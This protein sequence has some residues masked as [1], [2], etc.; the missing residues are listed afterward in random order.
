TVRLKEK[1]MR[2][3]GSPARSQGAAHQWIR[4]NALGLVAIFIAL[5]GTALATNLA[6]N[7]AASSARS[8]RGPAGPQGPVGPPGPAGG[9]G[10]VGAQGSPGAPGQNG[11]PDTGGQ[12]LSKLA[13]VD[14]SGSGLD[15]DTLDG[16][17]STSFV[18]P[19]TEAWHEIG[20]FE[21]GCTADNFCSVQNGADF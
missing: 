17:N 5:S 16:Q 7:R 19:G 18:T 11:S 2:R 12:I 14:G 10:L 8:R 21:D 15:A 6:S 20:P 9:Q 4:N 1:E 3:T 13:P